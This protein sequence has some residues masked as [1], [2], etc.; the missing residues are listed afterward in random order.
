[1]F[2][3]V[4]DSTAT[5]SPE[6][7]SANNIAVVPLSIL[8]NGKAY[9][10]GTEISNDEFYEKIKDIKDIPKTS[11]PA[12][13]SF[14]EAYQRLKEQ[15]IT[16]VLSIHISTGISGTINSAKAA[17]EQIKD[18]NIHIIDSKSLSRP[19][20]D[21]VLEAAK[22][23]GEGL[24]IEQVK[25]YIEAMIEKIKVYCLV[26]DLQFLH[27][28]GRV[29]GVSYFLGSLLNINP[30]VKVNEEGVI[31]AHEKVRSFKKAL[32]RLAEYAQKDIQDID[33]RVVVD[34]MYSTS[35]E[36]ANSLKAQIL[37]AQPGIE[38]QLKSLT[39]VIGSHTGRGSIGLGIMFY[40]QK[41]V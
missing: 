5:L 34:V 40:P 6:E 13:G 24:S 16:E 31:T 15:G 7:I 8:L 11:Q 35:L 14:V 12:V 29:S 10:E 20:G 28:G 39:P 9:K 37:S 26:G 21:L 22:L 3:L 32:A 36:D 18:M 2:G 1:M 19:V 33:D 23:R 25:S 27:K 17:A 4:T 38:V 30:I 41:D